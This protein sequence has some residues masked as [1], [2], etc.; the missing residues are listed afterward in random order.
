M[1]THEFRRKL[2]FWAGHLG[3][4]DDIKKKK[5]VDNKF[6]FAVTDTTKI[7]FIKKLERKEIKVRYELGWG[8]GFKP[9]GHLI[10]H[11]P[12]RPTRQLV[13]CIY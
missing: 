1:F 7:L 11:R 10:C 5:T 13:L 3:D 9:K 12:G 2:N 4:T 6:D 8:R